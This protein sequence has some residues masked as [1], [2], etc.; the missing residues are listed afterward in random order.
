MNKLLRTTLTKSTRITASARPPVLPPFAAVMEIVLAF[1]AIVAF[2]W[3]VPTVDVYEIRP[4]PFWIP[5][6]LLSLQYG[7]VSGLL[8]ATVAIA[9]TTLN[10]F[11]E[12]STSDSFFTYFL[13]IWIEPILWIGAAVLLGQFRMRQIAA[14]QDLARQVVELSS[15]R[16]AIADHAV[17]L[18]AHC[19]ALER[20]IAGRREPDALRLLEALQLAAGARPTDLRAH[21]T[22]V[23]ELAFPNARAS[24]YLSDGS[25]LR[26][27]AT[28]GSGSN[29]AAGQS[30]ERNHAL[31]DAIVE[32]GLSLSVLSADG[33][34]LL[35]GQGLAAVPVLHR[36]A[37]GRDITL[38]A[39]GMLM[40]EA[41]DAS[42]LGAPA[43]TGLPILAAAFAP[44][45]AAMREAGVGHDPAV[46]G[47]HHLPVA[48]NIAA[49]LLENRTR[50]MRRH[51]WLRASPSSVAAKPSSRTVR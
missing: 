32:H 18:R 15:Q 13:K 34:R 24:L 23:V 20:R 1:S 30:F 17:N 21:F 16:A 28:C 27:V 35:D 12:Q 41:V 39:L 2:G 51:Q 9:L 4:H 26:V 50:F 49:K 22:S 25:I 44:A 42:L 3:V 7:T 46:V 40:I 31:Y 6:L 38:P 5:V 33:E 11:P 19:N 37:T 45:L 10:G 43:M 8:A 47:S 36:A 14:K 29:V 48:T